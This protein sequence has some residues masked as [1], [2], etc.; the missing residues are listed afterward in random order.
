MLNASRCFS[1]Q[2]VFHRAKPIVSL[3]AE[4]LG[5]KNFS[6]LALLLA[7]W[8]MTAS[9][10]QAQV[11]GVEHVVVLGGD[12]MGSVAFR[13]TNAP[14]M[15]RL[16]REGAYTLKARGVIPTSSSPNWASMIMGAGPEQHG[17]TSNEW[18]TNKFEIA[19]LAMNQWGLFP[20]IFGVLREQRPKAVL[21]AVHDWDDFGRLLERPAMDVV[22]HVK[23]SPATARRAI[24]VIKQRQPT[25]TFVHFDDIDHAG[26]SSQWKSDAYYAAVEMVDG[27]MGE[28]LAAIDSTSMKGKTLVLV[29]ADH[30]GIGTKHGG[31]TQVELD[32]PWILHG[33]G[34]AKGKQLSTQV[35]TYDTA[36]TI[37]HAFGL[38]T[39]SCWIG[40]PV[41][42]AFTA[43]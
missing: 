16:M 15:H 36:A 27:L 24:E 13:A 40:K 6:A 2:S 8:T 28:I 42:E 1:F 4:R 38:K 9:G 25:F 41:T 3:C 34:V 21:V 33:P 32:I 43:R 18:Q 11:R 31:M 20:T 26:H 29:T 23:G 10:A 12:G 22:E 7:A 37:A 30:G 19:P 39:P 35:N 14:V 5:R 17:V